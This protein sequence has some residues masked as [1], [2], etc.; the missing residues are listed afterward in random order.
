MALN[1]L[2]I[3]FGVVLLWHILHGLGRGFAVE[4]GYV[5]AQ[6]VSL[7]VGVCALWVAWSGATWAVVHIPHV[8]AAHI[9]QWTVQV[10]QLWQQAPGVARVVVFLVIYFVVSGVLNALLRGVAIHIP[11]IVPGFIGKSRLLGAM[12]GVVVGSAYV[13]IAGGLVFLA[14]QYLSIPALSR[15][16]TASGPYQWLAKQVYEPRMRPLLTRE[17]PVYV[18]SALQPLSKNINMFVLP[19]GVG[20]E[21]AVLVVPKQIAELAQ[22]ITIGQK[23]NRGKAYA[24]YE[25]EIHHIHYDWKKY[26]DYVYRGKW[27][28]QSPLQTLET[29]K[30]VCADYA[31]LYAD[32][33]HSVRLTVQIDEGLGGM[34]G[35]LGS[36]AW[37]EVWDA[38]AN[39]WI[40]VDTT[41]GSQ[42]GAWFDAP[43]FNQ[44]HIRQVK[45]LIEGASP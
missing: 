23:T 12:L 6:I 32:M 31:L 26:D 18:E 27:D 43:D 4:A 13:M 44:T 35:Q 11:R 21:R 30:G 19:T 42:Q 40:P 14:L 7:A 15:V 10:V 25:W 45:I 29:G 28:Q 33:A 37:N 16:A 38:Q 3:A 8:N 9:P 24:L 22:H 20:Q 1:W 36:H 41:W 5:L 34:P 39:R 17:L 2:T